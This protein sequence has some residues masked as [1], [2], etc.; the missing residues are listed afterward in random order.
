MSADS[1]TLAIYQRQRRHR[2]DLP[3]L[4]KAAQAALPHCL[5]A[6]K[7]DEAL[8]AVLPE[9][10]ISIV[11][12]REIGRVHGQFMGD[13]SPTDVITFQHG[14]ILISADTAA[15]QGPENGHN[16]E[17]ELLLYIIHGLLQLAGWNDKEP[18]EQKQMHAVQDEVLRLVGMS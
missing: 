3:S 7:G 2:V 1:P 6:S 5:A 13:P 16:L 15:L 11:S 18:A 12:D 10:E 4:R 8:L 9:V 17:K 14:E